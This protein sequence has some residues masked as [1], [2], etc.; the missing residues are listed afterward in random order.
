MS[1]DRELASTFSSVCELDA[2]MPD[3]MED[4]FHDVI[5]SLLRRDKPLLTHQGYLYESVRKRIMY[6]REGRM[7]LELEE[8]FRLQSRPVNLDL[9]IDIRRAIRKLGLKYRN[10]LYLYYY[11]GYKLREIADRYDVSIVRIHGIIQKGLR[12]MKVI[13]SD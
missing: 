11:E 1:L 10:C 9:K 12:Q 2:A 5:V 13:L 7:D 6:G 3:D 8:E 4:Y